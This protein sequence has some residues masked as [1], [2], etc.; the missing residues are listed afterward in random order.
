VSNMLIIISINDM[1]KEYFYMTVEFSNIFN[2]SNASRKLR[3][4]YV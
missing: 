3:S 1:V 4:I 2:W